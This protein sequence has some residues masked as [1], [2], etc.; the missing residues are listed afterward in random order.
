MGCP[1]ESILVPNFWKLTI[2]ELFGLVQK[3]NFRLI[4]YTDDILATINADNRRNLV[5]LGNSVMRHIDMLA[6]A[7]KLTIFLQNKRF[8]PYY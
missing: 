5:D 7:N 3:Y 8:H 1:Q 2:D 6:T 4:A